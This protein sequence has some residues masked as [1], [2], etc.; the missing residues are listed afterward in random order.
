MIP[1]ALMQWLK[2]NE[3]LG[4]EKFL[5]FWLE[6]YREKE[7]LVIPYIMSWPDHDIRFKAEEWEHTIKFCKT[8]NEIYWTSD[9]CPPIEEMGKGYLGI[10]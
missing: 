7:D 10:P 3:N 9:A 4:S 1:P 8:F 2:K 5:L 6:W